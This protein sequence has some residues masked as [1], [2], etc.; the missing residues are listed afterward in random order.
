[1]TRIPDPARDRLE[2][3]WC[4]A[5]RFIRDVAHDVNN[6]LG[7]VMAYGDL[8][9][10]DVPDDTAIGGH[11]REISNAAELSSRIIDILSSLVRPD[12]LTVQEVDLVGVVRDVSLLF[13]REQRRSETQL[14]IDVPSAPCLI[15]GVHTRLAR[16]VTHTL[17]IAF[18]C[19]WAG[20]PPRT[21]RLAL[22]RTESEYLLRITGSATFE[23]RDAGTV[24]EMTEHARHHGGEF[25]IGPEA[26][27]ITVPRTTG[28]VLH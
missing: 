17:R 7:A 3:N 11:L 12:E 15:T 22:G 28:L 26:I 2:R 27:E 5:G 9:G 21:L 6:Q 24:A 8:I 13:K 19:A 23:G 10:L 25:R 18:D 14:E 20:P 4:L 1:M 16:L